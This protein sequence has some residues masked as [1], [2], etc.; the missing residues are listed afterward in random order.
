M[1][2]AMLVTLMVGGIFGGAVVGGRPRRPPPHPCPWGEEVVVIPIA[3]AKT[4]DVVTAA[5]VW[6][7]FGLEGPPLVLIAA[8]VIMHGDNYARVG[9]LAAV[10]LTNARVA[11][12]TD[13]EHEKSY[14]PPRSLSVFLATDDDVTQVDCKPLLKSSSVKMKLDKKQSCHA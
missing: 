11:G 14:Q 4:G 2:R 1:R 6:E 8:D 13:H 5:D 3:T 12:A 7:E 9:V 10:D